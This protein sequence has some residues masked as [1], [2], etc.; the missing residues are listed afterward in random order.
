MLDALTRMIP[1]IAFLLIGL[2]LHIK[3][4]VDDQTMLVVKKGIIS[5]ALPAVLFIAFKNMDLRKEYVLIS[6]VIFVMMIAFYMAGVVINRVL[7]LNSVILPFLTTG[8]AFGL[9]GIP[10][11]GG[12]YGLEN[13]GT[14]SIF[15]VGHEFFA[16]F[17]YLTLIRKKLNNEKFGLDTIKAFFSSPIIIAILSGVLVNVLNFGPVIEGFFISKGILL[18][19]ESIA[20]L[21]TPLI[22]IIV[23][24]GI[25]F[26]KAYIN[27]AIQIVMIRLFVVFVIGYLMKIFIMTPILGSSSQLFDMAFFTFLVLPPPFMFAIFAS[28]YSTH[29]NAAVANNAIVLS[30]LLCVLLFAGGVM[31]MGI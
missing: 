24:F 23:G 11:F 28:D 4:L 22:L 5:V 30:T 25:R 29:E 27:K 20:S 19:L 17:I 7:K 13:V 10:L 2:V 15:G 8:F 1:I 9:L 12:V 6:I 3:K 21:T 18:T 26:E 16:W 14:L 31:F